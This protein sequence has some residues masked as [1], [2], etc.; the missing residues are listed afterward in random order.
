MKSH[1]ML[2]SGPMVRALLDGRKAQTRRIVKDAMT[3]RSQFAKGP[4]HIEG[5]VWSWRDRRDGTVMCKFAEIPIQVGDTIWVREAF[6]GSPDYDKTPPKEWAHWPVHYEADGS[7]II[8]NSGKLR[9]PI[10]MPR[11]AS[12]ITLRVTDVRVE[13]LQDISE[14]DAKAEGLEKREGYECS[15]QNDYDCDWCAVQNDSFMGDPKTAFKLLWNSINGDGAWDENPWVVAY[16]FE[17][18]A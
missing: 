10:H 2:F 1:P 14:T 13:R 9:P 16:T 15:T 8:D 3:V 12:R 6:R 18:T 11:W 7:P 4:E 17:A 5:K